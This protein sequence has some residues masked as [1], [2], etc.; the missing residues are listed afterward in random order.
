VPPNRPAGQSLHDPAP[1][2]LYLPTPHTTAV[3][4]T[5]PAGHAYPALQFPLQPAVVRPGPLPNRPAGHPLHTPAAPT[6]YCPGLHT[7]AVATTDPDGHAY[8]AGHGPV[9]LPVVAPTLAP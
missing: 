3:A 4:L 2:T 8:P 5:D 6:E 7:T 9:Q 1:P